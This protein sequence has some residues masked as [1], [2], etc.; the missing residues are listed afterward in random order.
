[1]DNDLA[2]YMDTVLGYFLITAQLDS[3][4][5]KKLVHKVLGRVRIL[6]AVMYWKKLQ[7]ATLFGKN[8]HTTRELPGVA[9]VN[10]FK[11]VIFYGK[12]QH[13]F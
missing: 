10:I 9:L 11:Q 2:F 13:S 6:K 7:C 8:I 12:R 4:P 5:E 3:P 1:M